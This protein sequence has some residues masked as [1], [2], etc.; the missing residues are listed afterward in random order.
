MSLDRVLDPLAE[1]LSTELEST[2]VSDVAPAVAGDLPRVVL[3]MSDVGQ[4]LSGVGR[5]PRGTQTGSLA[6]NATI[7]LAN[8]VLDLGNG[9]SL[10]LLSG[11]RKTLTLPNGP[12][13]RADGTTDPPFSAADAS[14]NDGSAFTLVANSP[15]GRQF[16][17]DPIQGTFIFGAKLATSGT[18]RV[19]Y[20]IG[21]WDSGVTRAIGTLAIDVYAIGADQV[22]ALARLVASATALASDGIRAEPTGWSPVVSA[23]LP[24]DSNVRTQRLAFHLD[25]EVEDAI[26]TTSGGVI[27][28]IDVAGSLGDPADPG[29]LPSIEPFTVTQGAPT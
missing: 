4:A 26:L 5:L 16:T 15:T 22:R 7:D 28:E 17:V 25:A 20:H 29:P 2:P 1:K 21:Q 27:T 24:D 13:V 14:A 19:G 12:V 8:P 23:T 11:D 6:V 3:S 9:E 10:N 18:L